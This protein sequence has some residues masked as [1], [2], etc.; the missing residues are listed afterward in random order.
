MA[1]DAIDGSDVVAVRDSVAT[2]V[3]AARS[4]EGPGFL[5]VVTNRLHGHFEGDAQPYRSQRDD[6]EE[7]R[8]DPIANAIGRLGDQTEGEA[9]LRAAEEEMDA[10]VASALE[11][12]YPDAADLLKDV[13]A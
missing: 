9:I 10:A 5:E 12:P 1:A 3:A 13:Y 11:A 2:L 6:E 4:G 7:A 8:L